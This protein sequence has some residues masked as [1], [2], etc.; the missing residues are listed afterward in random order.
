MTFEPTPQPT[1]DQIRALVTPPNINVVTKY[2]AP[3]IVIDSH[4]ASCYRKAFSLQ[5]GWNEISFNYRTVFSGN[6]LDSHVV[7][8]FNG[9]I[10]GRIYPK[11]CVDHDFVYQVNVPTAGSYVIEFC[12]NGCVG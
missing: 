3:I 6:V 8:K 11:D 9:Q 1:Y 10:I 2:I 7:I 12:P 4:G 5:A